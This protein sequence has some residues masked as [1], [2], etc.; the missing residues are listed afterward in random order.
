MA[1]AWPAK[2]LATFLVDQAR[3]VGILLILFALVDALATRRP[4]RGLRVPLAIV[5]FYLV[6]LV[7]PVA[8]T[9]VAWEG[10]WVLGIAGAAA[11]GGCGGGDG[12]AVHPMDTAGDRES[13]WA[14]ESGPAA[15]LDQRARI[16]RV[17]GGTLI[18][19]SKSSENNST[20][21]GKHTS[22]C[23]IVLETIHENRNRMSVKGTMS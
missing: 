16:E 1:T 10:G 18:R 12:L 6:E 19:L 2:P 21:H 14:W 17:G 20:G 7:P 9:T 23:A 22:Q 11:W 13:S 4:F 5:P 8:S 3:G 15:G